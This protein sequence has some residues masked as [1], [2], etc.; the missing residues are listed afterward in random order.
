MKKI[1]LLLNVSLLSLFSLL[2]PWQTRAQ[3]TW[4][5]LKNLAP[6]SEG[7]GMVLLTDGR[8]MCK[9]YYSA[10]GF[11]GAPDSSWM[12]LTPDMHGSYVNGTWSLLPAEHDTR[13]V[14]SSQ[15]L[16]TGNV[17]IGGGEHGSG[18]SSAEL[19]N[20]TTNTWKYLPNIPGWGIYDANSELLYDG[21]VIIGAALIYN[22][23]TTVLIYNPVTG[24]LNAGPRSIGSHEE[25][26][27]LKLPD[28]SILYV[29]TIT[30]NSERY[31]PKLHKW[32][33]D[34]NVP[35]QLY[36]PS[37]EETGPATL[38]PN[39]KG[40]FIGDVGYTA[41]YTPSGDTNPGTWATG[42]NEPIATGSVQLGSW[43]GP[44]A[45]MVNG[46]VLY[47]ISPLASESLPSY[48]YE[49][50]YVSNTFLR[51][52]AP[53]GGDSVETQTN[54]MTMLDLPDGTILFAYTDSTKFYIYTP[55]GPP[56][57]QGKPTI[58]GLFP[59]SCNRYMITGKLFNGISEGAEFGDD[60]QMSTNYPVIRLTSGTNVYYCR[61]TNW[62][63]LGAVQTDSAEDTAYFTL[64]SLPGGTY[65]LV[66]TAN[67]FAS[68]PVSLTTFGVAV[69]ATN[70]TACHGTGTA[71]A[72]ASYGTKPYTYLWS[73]S[74]G[75][76]SI[77]SGLSG[78]TYT[79]TV[80]EVGGCTASATVTITTPGTI[81]LTATIKNVS[82]NGGSNGSVSV[83]ASGGLSPY[84]YSWSNGATTTSISGLTAGTY[85][86]TVAD[87]CGYINTKSVTLIQPAGLSVT[88][89]VTADNKC[90]GDSS[91]SANTTVSGGTG[92]YTYNWNPG[93]EATSNII[94][95]TAGTYTVTVRDSCGATV[96]A[97]ATITQPPALLVKLDSVNVTNIVSC[98]GKA[99]A[100]ASGGTPPFTYK[101][102][103]GGQ[104]IDSIYNQ[105]SGAYCC[106]V[107]DNSGCSKS[108]CIVI[109]NA[110]EGIGNISAGGGQL[111]VY[112]NPSNG[113][114]TIESS[115]AS[116]QWSVQVYNM[117]GQ[118]VYI[119]KL[120]ATS[121]QI[122][123]SANSQGIY[124][125][126]VITETGSLV[127]EGK[128]IIQK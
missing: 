120:N 110:T 15:V 74:G 22:P 51:V 79:I 93:G 47:S 3:G 114:F 111:S 1:K 46:N 31:I 6:I 43:D 71:T 61:T 94:S 38:L 100:I 128:F 70:I 113:I 122:D 65:S 91:G 25:T 44:C 48:F 64:P 107:T 81:V 63:R 99:K 59:D 7:G 50:N 12:V 121:T 49:Y 16:P 67:G 123:L 8:V 18:G 116:N 36:D 42:P 33:A 4:T 78:G 118:Q 108:V 83:A 28:S 13:S 69:T 88:A 103:P 53:G 62:N 14:F 92:L 84:T 77:A 104:T 30:T 86:V 26:S 109:N 32:I 55:S 21:T 34:A 102:L 82:C 97:T 17:Y 35:V 119:G 23:D 41:I 90:Y 96:T 45:A 80:T 68:S 54:M 126:R 66:V 125:Y 115:V 39:G 2:L 37:S 40:F 87:S 24:T 117:M 72:S 85:S 56:I 98:N 5:A 52:G 9:G 57:P 73:P 20:T 27:W 19:F 106:T 10:V 75:T 112:P 95:L 127:G 124:L 11:P 89:N 58:D 105:C 29:N 76:D 60:W 101:W